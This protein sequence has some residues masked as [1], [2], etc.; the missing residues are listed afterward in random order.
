MKNKKSVF[1]LLLAATVSVEAVAHS[2]PNLPQVMTVPE[3]VAAF[4]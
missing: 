4:G 3:G 2:A 1:G